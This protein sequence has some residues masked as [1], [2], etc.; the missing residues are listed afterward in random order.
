MSLDPT[1]AL[2]IVDVQNDFCPG[3]SLAVAEGDRVIPVLNDYARFFAEAGAAVVAT[4]DWHPDNHLSF[5]EQGGIWPPHCIRDSHGA[6]FHD[7]LALPDDTLVVSKAQ[8]PDEEAYSGFQGTGLAELLRARGVERV[9]VGGL[10][11]DYCVK[12][13]VL[14]ALEAGFESYYLADGSRGVEVNPGDVAEAEAEMSAAGAQ[15]MTL[16]DL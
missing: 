12:S 3:G 5:V 11:T 9:Y 4:R 7:E 2:I 14:D 10:A 6:A 8:R 15:A 1:A 16:D 13:T